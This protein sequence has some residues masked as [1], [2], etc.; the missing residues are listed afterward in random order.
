M[1]PEQLTPRVLGDRVLVRQDPPS[2]TTRGGIIIPSVADKIYPSTGTVVAV[3]PKNTDVA[4][5]QRVY[6]ARRAASALV[7]DERVPDQR[8]DWQGLLRL[9]AEDILAVIE[10]ES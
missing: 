9:Y 2:E 10:D 6:F 3:G 5:G 7:Q 8:E 4:V 1:I